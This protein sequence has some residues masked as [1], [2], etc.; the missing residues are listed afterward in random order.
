MGEGT[1]NFGEPTMH[2]LSALAFVRI[3][4]LDNKAE[5]VERAVKNSAAACSPHKLLLPNR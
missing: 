2:R 1:V 5:V 3:T 4:S